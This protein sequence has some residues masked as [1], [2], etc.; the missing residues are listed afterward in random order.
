MMAEART[1]AAAENIANAIADS[2]KSYLGSRN[3]PGGQVLAVGLP[4]TSAARAP[5]ASRLLLPGGLG[6]LLGVLVGGIAA[7]AVGGGDRPL[8]EGAGIADASGVPA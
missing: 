3:A 6:G 4:P 8:R 7:M 2:Y 5:L 1:A